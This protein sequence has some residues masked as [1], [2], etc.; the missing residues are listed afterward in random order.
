MFSASPFSFLLFL[1]LWVSSQIHL[2]AGNPE[3]YR[4]CRYNLYQCGN[5]TVGYPFWGNKREDYCGHPQLELECQEGTNT[6][7]LRIQGVNF[8]VLDINE[9][10]L[11]LKIARK[12]F[13][14]D[15]CA[16]RL[17][18]FIIG[19]GSLFSYVYAYRNLTIHYGCQSYPDDQSSIVMFPACGSTSGCN[20]YYRRPEDDDE[21]DDDDSKKCKERVTVRIPARLFS[22]YVEVDKLKEALGEEIEVKVMIHTEACERCREGNGVC[23]LPYGKEACFC[24]LSSKTCTSLIPAFLLPSSG[25]NIYI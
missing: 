24:D 6:T 19:Q 10:S 17:S 2:S 1:P 9:S 5:V 15:L 25:I 13:T 4:T 11:L 7:V 22:P 12:D 21:E 3:L 20:Y 18:T 14:G 23:G 8:K 16:P